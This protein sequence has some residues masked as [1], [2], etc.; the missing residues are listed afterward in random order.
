MNQVSLLDND[1]KMCYNE[2]VKKGELPKT[3]NERT[4][5]D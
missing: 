3:E 1:A 5:G 4:N 2:K